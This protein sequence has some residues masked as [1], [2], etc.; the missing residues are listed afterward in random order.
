MVKRLRARLEQRLVDY[1]ARLGFMHRYRRFVHGPEDR[2]HDDRGKGGVWVDVMLNTRSGHIYLE[3][4]V[5]L[6]H[7]CMLLTGRHEYAEGRLKPRK[8]QVPDSGWDIRIGRGSWIASGA[9]VIGGVTIGEHSI[10][11]AGAVVTSDVPPHT[12]VGGNPARP[13]GS[14]LQ[15]GST[16]TSSSPRRANSA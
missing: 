2:I 10:V 12:I 11:A 6:G 1:L 8:E 3:R 7:G 13:I 9:I 14:T 16:S 15:A 4:D 5:I